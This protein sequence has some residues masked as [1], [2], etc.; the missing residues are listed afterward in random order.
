MYYAVLQYRRTGHTQRV[1]WVS[2]TAR[3]L[4]LITLGD[5]VTVLDE[6]LDVYPQQE[7]K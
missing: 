2:A 1:E 5:A 4:A 3:A 6:G 7:D